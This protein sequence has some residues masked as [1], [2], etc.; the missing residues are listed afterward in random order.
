MCPKNKRFQNLQDVD[1]YSSRLVGIYSIDIWLAYGVFL[2][3]NSVLQD[4]EAFE[5]YYWI[6]L[7]NNK[8][9]TQFNV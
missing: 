1:I 9:W 6:M 4:E 2:I 5:V 3:F 7:K 8:S